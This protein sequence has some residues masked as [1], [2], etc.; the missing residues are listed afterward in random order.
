VPHFAALSVSLL[1]PWLLL[2][3]SDGQRCTFFC[4]FY[5]LLLGLVAILTFVRDDGSVASTRGGDVTQHGGS[6]AMSTIELRYRL[7][8]HF[9][10]IQSRDFILDV[11]VAR[12]A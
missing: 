4:E 9:E 10:S 5:C 1:E 7:G 12:T 11:S 6:R 8:I 2:M 3:N